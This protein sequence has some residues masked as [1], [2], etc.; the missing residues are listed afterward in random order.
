MTSWGGMF[1]RGTQTTYDNTHFMRIAART[2][3]ASTTNPRWRRRDRAAGRARG[4]P[5]ERTETDTRRPGEPQR[6]TP[7]D[8]CAKDSMA[9]GPR[10]ARLRSG[11]PGEPARRGPRR[12]GG[13]SPGPGGATPGS[14]RRAAP[15]RRAGENARTRARPETVPLRR[16]AL[17][18]GP[19]RPPLQKQSGDQS[20]DRGRRAGAPPKATGY[21]REHP[22][23][24]LGQ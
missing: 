21:H 13:H 14:T 4:K 3:P 19:A 2:S 23:Q 12:R 15:A 6:S 7:L 16:S 22:R 24:W 11:R 8:P 9:Q 18:R 5:A 20:Q 10:T 17:P 1:T